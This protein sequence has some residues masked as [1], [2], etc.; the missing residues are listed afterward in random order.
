MTRLVGLV[1]LRGSSLA[2]VVR[3]LWEPRGGSPTI[4]HESHTPRVLAWLLAHVPRRAWLSSE[5]GQ[6]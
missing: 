6:L 5:G 3:I 4:S 1:G 2:L